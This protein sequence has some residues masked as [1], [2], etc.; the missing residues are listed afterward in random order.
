MN[1]KYIIIFLVVLFFFSCEKRSSKTERQNES[2]SE[3]QGGEISIQPAALS[4]EYP[5][6]ILEMIQPAEYDRLQPGK[7]AFRYDVKNFDLSSGASITVN[8]NNRDLFDQKEPEFTKVLDDGFYFALAFLTTADH[9]SLKNYGNYVSRSVNVGSGDGDID[10]TIP[11]LMYNYPRGR[12]ALDEKNGIILDFFLLNADLSSGMQ[13]RA[14]ID[15]REFIL[16]EWR[17]YRI[18]GL[19]RGRHVLKLSLIDQSGRLL[20]SPFNQ[21][22]GE[23][24]L[25]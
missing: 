1:H 19:G 10:Q 6:A 22:E 7:V 9:I 11:M 20:Q 17:P 15:G 3:R 13:V 4:P 25:F 24:T 16:N 2:P 5:D 23:F 12:I 21:A 8:L 18:R 14:E